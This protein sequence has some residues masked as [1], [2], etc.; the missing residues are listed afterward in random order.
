MLLLCS[1][2]LW[3][4]LDEG[5]IGKMLSENT[6]D[7]AVETMA[8]QAEFK[9]YPNSDNISVVAFQWISDEPREKQRS[10]RAHET[11]TE[12]SK[13]ELKQTL[14]ELDSALGKT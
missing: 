6:I 14:D 12:P 9:A 13:D 10:S 8:Y 3:G 5:S 7:K 2:G 1:D 4:S 11:D